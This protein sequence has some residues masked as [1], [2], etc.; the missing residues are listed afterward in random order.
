MTTGTESEIDRLRNALDHIVKTA[1]ASHT[2]TRRIRWIEERARRALAGEE[3]AAPHDIDLPKR[4]AEVTAEH[5]KKKLAVAK[6][7]NYVMA[8]AGSAL[9]AQLDHIGMTREEQPLMD[10]LREAIADATWVR[11]IQVDPEAAVPATAK[12]LDLRIALDFA[13]KSTS[14]A[15]R[16]G[17]AE[18]LAILLGEDAESFPDNFMGSHAIADTGDYGTHWENDKLAALL[19]VDGDD[20]TLSLIDRMEATYWQQVWQLGEMTT[21]LLW[22]LYHHQGFNSEIGQPARRVLGMGRAQRLS[23]EQLTQAG[24]ARDW[25]GSEETHAIAEEAVPQ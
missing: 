10:A 15:R 25:R 9:L 5:L 3:F 22:I 2:R 24:Q 11:D 1:R 8:E 17:R 23:A 20:S 19:D 6:R 4:P 13:R 12:P 14:S 18:A 16:A 21:V 7:H